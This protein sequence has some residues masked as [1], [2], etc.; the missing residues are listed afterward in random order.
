[1]RI[2]KLLSLDS[3]PA[4]P[5]LDRATPI[6]LTFIERIKLPSAFVVG[7][8]TIENA[9]GEVRPLEVGD[10]L[11]FRPMLLMRRLFI[12]LW[13]IFIVRNE[14]PGERMYVIRELLFL[15]L[16]PKKVTEAVW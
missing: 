11:V 2:T 1:M 7:D 8:Q 16:S 12:R 14:C 15:C 9:L 3:E 4:K 10:V 6:A 13:G 5:I